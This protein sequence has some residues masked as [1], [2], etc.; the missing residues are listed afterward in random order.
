M[1]HIG[2]LLPESYAILDMRVYAGLFSLVY[3]LFQFEFVLYANSYLT[4]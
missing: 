4:G 3:I 1:Y 2:T